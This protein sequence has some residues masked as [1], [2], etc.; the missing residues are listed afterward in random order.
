[1]NVRIGTKL[2]SGFILVSLFV[3]LAGGLGM[4]GMRRISEA[5]AVVL[6]DKVP[7]VNVALA[8]EARAAE[9]RDVLGEYLLVRS[10]DEANSLQSLQREFN[11]RVEAIDTNMRALTSGNSDMGVAAVD[12]SSETFKLAEDSLKA[13]DQL[14]DQAEVLM[15]AHREALALLPQAQAGM[16]AMDAEGDQLIAQVRS[17]N[18]PTQTMMTLWEQL[19]AVND[20]LIRGDEA[21]VDSFH[22]AK[23]QIES[24]SNYPLIREK[25]VAVSRLGE[26]TIDLYDKYREQEEQTRAAM[27]EVDTTSAEFQ[28]RMGRISAAAGREMEESSQAAKNTQ[29]SSTTMLLVITGIAVFASLLLGISISR[30]I[31]KP[32]EVAVDVSN[33][34]AEG[35]LTARIEVKSQ[36]EVGQLLAAMRNMV[37]K[38]TRI[39]SEVRAGANSVSSAGAQ[40]SSTSQG[41]S[42]GTSEQAASVEETTS[43]L[44][45]MSAS[46]SQN[47]ENSRQTEQM[48]VKGAQEA[49]ESGKAVGET[50]DAMKSIAGKISIIEEIA[51][52][53]NLLALNAAIE[54][55]RAGEHGKGF[56]V[57]AT[58]VR[59]LAERSQ[60]AA[61]EISGLADSSVEVAEGAGRS[62]LELVPSIKKTTELV[63]EVA[64][65][66]RE[67][68]SGVEQANTAMGQ[69]DEVTQRNASS[70]EELSSTAEEMASQA[71]ALQQ[72]MGFFR[73]D[74]T[75]EL[76]HRPA[77]SVFHAPDATAPAVHGT[78]S[79]TVAAH[80]AAPRLA[81]KGDGAARNVPE[82]KGQTSIPPADHGEQDFKRF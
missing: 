75:A 65:A 55:A 44:E 21:E 23:A 40:V 20:Y 28:G 35:D 77:A 61:K 57:V 43:S 25:H 50:V 17:A 7:V 45:Q 60:A 69:M 63:Q 73:V 36:D 18:L 31:T 37:E 9:A 46:I 29:N 1:M 19:M 56:A 5:T 68:S 66:S 64:A 32:L 79:P 42:Q 26:E 47:A 62:L 6:Y 72:L 38:L 12:P 24:S 22:D 52:Q 53:T 8:S 58:E 74:G 59:K 33:R 16:E 4:L 34:L 78:P 54:A 49:E 67:Q 14:K 10:S 11:D 2:V 30:S 27:E 70:A 3:G 82:P 71:E 51:Y 39:I 81:E 15:T 41:L 48:A 80:L 13:L 76:G